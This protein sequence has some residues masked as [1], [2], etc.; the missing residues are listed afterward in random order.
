MSA[1]Y[2]YRQPFAASGDKTAIPQT[3][4]DGT[5]SYEQ[6]YG[7]DY[8]LDP[9]TDPDAKRVP[10][11]PTNQL[12]FDLTENVRQYQLTG[13][14]EWVT[15]A[16]N[17]GSAV[18]Y[19]LGARVRLGDVTYT[20]LVAANTSTPGSDATRWL[21]TDPFSL[22]NGLAQPADYAT[23]SSNAL[24]T[25][26]GNLSRAIREARMTFAAAGAAGGTYVLTLSGQTFA[27]G[28][29][30]IVEFTV[31]AASPASPLTLKVNALATLPLQTNVETDL[32]A[33]DLQ[34][35]RVYTARST[36]SK[37]LL[38][39]P[40]LSQLASA[41]L[42]LPDRLASQTVDGA[43]LTNLNVVV[44]TGWYRAAAGVT[45]GP[46]ALAAQ[47]LFIQVETSDGNTATQFA[48]S[49]AT[50][51]EAN[52]NT[53]ARSMLAGAWGPWRRVYT[54][55]TEIQQA[56]LPAGVEAFHAGLT[57]PNGWLVR[58][59]AAVSR[60]TYAAL[61]AAIGT[62]YGAGDGTTTFNLPDD[63][64]PGNFT[65][66]G[67]PDG[68]SYADTV[69]PHAHQLPSRSNAN[70]GNGFVEDADSSGNV[71]TAYTELNGTGIGAET[72]PKHSRKLPIIKY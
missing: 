45:N 56:A 57:A 23:P 67:A 44:G 16:Q 20:S 50:S 42:T 49:L 13:T 22:T 68:V 12:Y 38:S 8:S 51:S 41:P 64:T 59:G 9:A 70:S 39:A 21:P 69:G 28:P 24:V 63:L 60:A 34:P 47:A 66:A 10:R 17:G 15:P 31:P 61:F 65:R 46:A 35:G 52:T 37:W 27:Q 30:A 14:P 2:F 40:V 62:I 71:Q 53:Y 25:S 43:A 72:A 1:Q 29:G 33:G 11:A 32:A 7:P 5:V 4:A 18:A 54:S 48:R 58:D 3:T 55:A 26:P 6:G 36:G 19:A